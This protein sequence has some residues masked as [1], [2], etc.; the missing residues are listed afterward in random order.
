MRAAQVTEIGSPPQMVELPEPV[1][2]SGE[3]LIA[4]SAASL[5]PV[6][7]RVAEGRM[8]GVSPPYV[9]GL[10]GV[11]TV[12]SSPTLA[13][14]TRVRFENDLPGFGK[15]GSIR[16]VA[17]AEQEALFELPA[18]VGDAEAAAAG[19]VGVTSEL[20][21][22][23][24]GMKGGERV[25]VLGATGGVGQM[26]VQLA[27]ARG[28]SAVVAV[29]RHRPSLEWLGSNGAT[30]SVDLNEAA[31][32]SAALLEAAGGPI[33]IVID[34][35]WGPPAMAAIA[36]LAEGGRLVT[37]GNTAGTDATLPLQAMRK[38]R[39]ALLGL[40]SGW[41]PLQEKMQAYGFV[42]E[43]MTAGRVSVAHEVHSLDGVSKAWARQRRFPHT[44]LV[45]SL[46]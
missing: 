7:L 8:P 14:G 12:I 11:G 18:S 2:N 34:P 31:D 30:A 9:P 25:A 20:A 19:V 35:L 16:E 22:G 32:L 39:S 26:A 17:V 21:Y 44:K 1:P 37:V 42:I 15:D 28:A 29:G 41:A 43:Q 45:I 27:A 40:S 6:E 3:T 13:A 5:N 4:V 36:V 46:S 38:A 33:D 24:A 10:E 23:L